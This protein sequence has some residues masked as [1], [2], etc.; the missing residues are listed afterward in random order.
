MIII[1]EEVLG[2]KL[3]KY[4]IVSNQKA[5]QLGVILIKYYKYLGKSTEEIEELMK[6]KIN[7]QNCDNEM[8][9]SYIYNTLMVNINIHGELRNTPITL[10][11]KEVAILQGID[12]DRF[13]RFT[14]TMIV[15]CK[16]FNNKLRVKK[17]EFMRLAELTASTN[18]FDKMFDKLFSF[19]YVDAKVMRYKIRESNQTAFYYCLTDRFF[20]ETQDDTTVAITIHDTNDPIIFYNVMFGK[21]VMDYC[22]E[23]GSPFFRKPQQNRMK[24]ICP[25]CRE[26][27]RLIGEKV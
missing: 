5:L 15:L 2:R 14:Y 23:C 4:G 3:D 10:N 16:A 21:G 18:E 8:L 22:E 27:K 19:G 24:S 1:N 26:F 20:E 7:I 25:D 11:Q 9:S 13:R 12:S 17:K 6:S